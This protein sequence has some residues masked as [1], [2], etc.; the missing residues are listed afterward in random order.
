M[1]FH[2]YLLRCSDQSYY[3]GHPDDLETRIGHHE[4]GS[5]D[6]YTSLQRPVELLQSE[7]F[8]TR[9]EALSAEL[10]LKKWTRAKKEAWVRGDFEAISKKDFSKRK[11]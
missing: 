3:V 10:R 9:E 4:L 1:A 7:A 2:V 8:G 6:G 11:T 5:V